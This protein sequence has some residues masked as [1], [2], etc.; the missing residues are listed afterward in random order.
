MSGLETLVA[1]SL[2]YNVF[3]ITSFASELY[4]TC[5]RLLKGETPDADLFKT[6][7]YLNAIF[8]DATQSLNSA[9]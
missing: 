6:L 9:T 4:T 7:V 5:T 8:N 1:L 3:Q 2:I